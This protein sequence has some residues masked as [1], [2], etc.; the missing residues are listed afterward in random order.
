MEV[1]TGTVAVKALQFDTIGADTV[2]WFA[3]QR[4]TVSRLL[5]RADAVERAIFNVPSFSTAY[6]QSWAAIQR[7]LESLAD[8]TPGVIRP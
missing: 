7:D 5:N 6:R 8:T 2:H 3:P 4:V 1:V